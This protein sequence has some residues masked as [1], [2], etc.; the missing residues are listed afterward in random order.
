VYLP[1][2]PWYA[3][4]LGQHF[5]GGRTHRLHLALDRIAVFERVGGAA[6]AREASA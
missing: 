2:G 5:D 6:L 3:P 4:L 1:A